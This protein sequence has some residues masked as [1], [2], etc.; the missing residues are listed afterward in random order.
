MD[1][2]SVAYVLCRIEDDS[3]L[4]P[5]S[6]HR[7][8]LTGI[9]AGG[10]AVEVEDHDFAYALYAGDPS[11]GSSHAGGLLPRGQDRLPPLG[12]EDGT[13]QP[14]RR[15]PLRPR[16]RRAHGVT[17]LPIERT[18]QIVCRLPRSPLLRP[19]LAGLDSRI[20]G[21]GGSRRMRVA[22]LGAHTPSKNPRP[23]SRTQAYIA[24]LRGINVLRASALR[25]SQ[26]F[27]NHSEPG[28]RE[29]SCAGPAFCPLRRSVYF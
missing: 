27:S 29:G 17:S 24:Y 2:T 1:K 3:S 16:R 22:L 4:T 28:R 25:S 11:N 19:A 10:Y 26:K 5:V 18:G 8:F 14:Q 6:R 20:A 12:H 7:D 13:H 21:G 15:G 23:V 9:A